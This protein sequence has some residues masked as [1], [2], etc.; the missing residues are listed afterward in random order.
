MPV[1]NCPFPSRKIFQYRFL[2]PAHFKLF[3]VVIIFLFSLYSGAEQAYSS[4]MGKAVFVKQ[5]SAASARSINIVSSG[6]ANPVRQIVTAVITEGKLTPTVTPQQLPRDSQL[7]NNAKEQNSSQVSQ[8][9]PSAA[10]PFLDALN[11]YRQRNGKPPLQWNTGL[12][13]YA[14]SRAD[15]FIKQ[16]GLDFHAGFNDFIHNQGG[17]YKLGFYSLGENSGFG[18]N[19]S[20]PAAIIE[21]SY[22]HS[23]EHNENQLNADWSNI[24][25][26]VSGSSTDF[27]FASH[28]M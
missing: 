26:G 28:G 4:Q 22:G 27:I 19:M 20:D 24:G 10:Q 18:H 16:G 12:G 21:N 17:F 25:I 14:Q 15:L 6:P 5:V 23:P 11:A 7:I 2:L 13:Q 1:N 3:S 8:P 9:C